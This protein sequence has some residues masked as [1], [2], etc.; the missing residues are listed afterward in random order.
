MAT[1]TEK[2][3]KRLEEEKQ[4]IEDSLSKLGRKDPDNPEGWEP[5][6]PMS[7]VVSADP[8][9]LADSFEE[10]ENRAALELQLVDQ[11]NNVKEALIRIKKGKYG[12]CER[13]GEEIE[14]DRLEAYPA[15]K[16]CM[17]HTS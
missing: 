1:D 15:A 3:K 14:K 11:L 7:D 12:I 17:K 4:K 16:T 8:S 5:N 9:D 6:P 13:G 2:F 10:F